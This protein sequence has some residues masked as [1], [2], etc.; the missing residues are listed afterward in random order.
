[1]LYFTDMSCLYEG[2]TLKANHVCVSRA[3]KPALA[4]L[5]LELYLAQEENNKW[6]KKINANMTAEM[7]GQGGGERYFP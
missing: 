5:S 2:D 6:E 4:A 3:Y 1:M 7:G